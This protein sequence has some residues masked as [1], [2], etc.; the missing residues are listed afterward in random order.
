M[1]TRILNTQIYR[2]DY[3]Q[4]LADKEKLIAIFLMTN[5][6]IGLYP[7]YTMPIREVAFYN[8]TT[9]SFV[10]E[11]LDK[12]Q[13]LGI[14]YINK[15]FI[16]AEKFT[17]SNYKG[18]KTQKAKE[19]EY[20]TIPKEI[21]EYVDE[22]GNIAQSLL[23][24]CSIIE[25]INHK[26]ETIN[27][28]SE[29]INNKKTDFKKEI[30][31]VIDKF[32]EVRDDTNIEGGLYER[33][34]GVIQTYKGGYMNVEH[35]NKYTNKDTNKITNNQK[36]EL[37]DLFWIKYPRKIGKKKAKDKYALLL[38]DNSHDE[39]IN[40][41]DMYLRKWKGIDK[42]FIPHPYTWLNQERWQDDIS[43]EL[44]ESTIRYIDGKSFNLVTSSDEQDTVRNNELRGAAKKLFD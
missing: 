1:K 13:P 29:T 35:T 32:N 12:L 38:K 20:E 43:D 18:G 21:R 22:E 9:E 39:I 44:E 11:V 25:H 26:P 36:D 19:R 24:H 2:D 15:Y 42:K 41:L 17:Y 14:F 5:D 16:I 8:N 4:E 10:E 37:F 27:Y 3:F 28:K 7:V 6:K 30:K 23:N 40:G 31:T 33:S 34:R